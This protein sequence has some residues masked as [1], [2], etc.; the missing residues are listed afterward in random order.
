MILP[1]TEVLSTTASP[2]CHLRLKDHL[3]RDAIMQ[4]PGT[5]AGGMEIF[6]QIMEISCRFMGRAG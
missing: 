2:D 5:L 4:A 1:V 6:E 3:G